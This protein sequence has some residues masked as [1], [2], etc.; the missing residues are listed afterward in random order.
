MPR[1]R[2]PNADGAALDRQS[3]YE[4]NPVMKK[5]AKHAPDAAA[6]GIN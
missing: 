4:R 1:Q 3:P 6:H 5:M 2:K